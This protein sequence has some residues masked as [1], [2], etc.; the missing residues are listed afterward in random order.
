MSAHKKARSNRA[1][2]RLRSGS[3]HAAGRKWVLANNR[4]SMCRQVFGKNFEMAAPAGS[5]SSPAPINA[6]I[7]KPANGDS[8]NT[9]IAN[10]AILVMSFMLYTS[11]KPRRSGRRPRTPSQLFVSEAQFRAALCLVNAPV[12]RH[13]PKQT[14]L[15]RSAAFQ[16]KARASLDRK[17]DRLARSLEK[18]GLLALNRNPQSNPNS[19]TGLG[20]SLSE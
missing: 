19:A 16:R 10:T 18:S 12:V 3:D 2:F 14:A 9:R 6:T 5:N 4:S 20:Y 1:F 15:P 8:A 13:Q 17:R 7:Q 11:R